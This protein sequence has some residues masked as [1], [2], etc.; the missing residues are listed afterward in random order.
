MSYSQ[1]TPPVTGPM[2]E[3]IRLA[4]LLLCL[5]AAVYLLVTRTGAPSSASS[6]G[7]IP[8]G[9]PQVLN[10]SA[11]QVSALRAS[12]E[13]VMPQRL[14]RL[15]EE[16]TVASSNAWTDNSPVTLTSAALRSAGYE[17]RWWATNHD[18]IVADVFQ[19]AGPHQAQEFLAQAAS[20]RC[21]NSAK[22][23]PALWPAQAHNLLWLNPDG[24]YQ[25]DVLFARA[26]RVYRVAAVLPGHV[27]AKPRRGALHISFLRVDDLA[28]LLPDAGCTIASG[29]VKV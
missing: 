16:G 24:F 19:F 20:T 5:A 28:C 23:A 1:E 8:A 11:E 2:N 27:E 17:M 18:D 12:V 25:E 22:Q 21:R 6:T 14:G 13:R 4:L 29:S 9:V 26:Q 3:W 10:V 7:C 15:Y